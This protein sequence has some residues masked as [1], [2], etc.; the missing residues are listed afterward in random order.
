MRSQALQFGKEII[1]IFT[2]WPII[3]R[4]F[5]QIV[6]VLPNLVCQ[7]HIFG[8]K[9]QLFKKFG[10]RKILGNKCILRIYKIMGNLA[11]IYRNERAPDGKIF[12]NF[13][14]KSCLVLFIG[15]IKRNQKR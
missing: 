2:I 12:R 3:E 13:L 4:F 15:R 14:A 9:L 5:A 11:D 1:K 10:R 6:A 7:F 8:N